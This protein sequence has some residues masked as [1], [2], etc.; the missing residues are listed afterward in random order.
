MPLHTFRGR[1]AASIENSSLRLTVVEG[2]GHIAE[3]LDKASGISPLWIPPWPSM[4]PAAFDPQTDT[5]YG[6]TAEARLLAGIMGHNLCLDIFGGPS[7]EE[8]AAGLHPHGEA[9]VAQYDVEASATHLT[10][11][12]VLA[13]A[14]LQVERS[15]ELQDRAVRI[16]ESVEN[17]AA[18]DRPVGWTEHVT[19]GPPFLERGSTQF[20]ASATRSKVIEAEFG[21]ADYLATGSEFD[22]PLA[23]RRGG[24]TADLRVFTSAEVSGAYT[25]HL[26]NPAELTAW[27]VAFNPRLQLAFGYIWK[28]ADFPWMGIWEENHSRSAPPWNGQTITRG[29]EFGVSPFP[30]SRRAMVDRGRMFGV[31]T[32][33]WV[34]ARTR[35]AVEYWLVVPQVSEVPERLEWPA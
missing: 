21:S 27:F 11:R 22:W 19:L 31:P 34:P 35:I 16:V 14:S 29:M 12:A 32:Y 17:L 9:S 23:P 5:A 30:E 15:I 28:Q 13:E 7:P 4:E 10:M 24:G 18:T 20:R 1:R 2:G 33:R 3:V 26:M 25:A 8:E 6:S